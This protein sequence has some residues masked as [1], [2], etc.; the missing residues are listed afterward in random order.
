M[1][2]MEFVF[3]VISDFVLEY[4]YMKV[5]HIEIIIILNYR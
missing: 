2:I 5:I 1:L 3:Q 4:A